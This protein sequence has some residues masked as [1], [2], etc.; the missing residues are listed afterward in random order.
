MKKNKKFIALI[1]LCVVMLSPLAC[2]KGFL[3]TTDSTA[4]TEEA[5]F[6]HSQDV[7]AMVNSVYDTYQSSDLLKKSI[8]YSANF[9]THDWYNNGS[10]IVW[11][12]YGIQSDFAALATLW[13]NAYVGIQRANSALQIITYAEG[14]GIVTPALGQRLTGE[15][16]FLRGTIYYYLTSVFGGVPLVLQSNTNGLQPRSTQDQCFQQ[17][18]ADMQQAES[19]LPSKTQYAA[20]DLGRATKGAAYGY[21]GA[22]QMWLKNYTAAMTAFTNTELTTNYS[23]VPSY[24]NVNEYNNQNNQES[25]FEVQFQISGSQS[26]DGGWQDGGEEAWIDDFDWPQEISGFGYDYANPGLEYS[27]EPG[28]TRKLATVAGPGDSLVSPGI[29]AK[30]GGIR[31]YAVVQAGFAANNSTYIGT[32]GKAI[33]TVGKV[34]QP[35][36]GTDGTPRSGYYCTKKWRDPTLTGANGTSAIFG[37]QNQVLLRYAEILLDEAE[38]EVHLGNTAQ[39]MAY[40]N[41]VRA[42]AFGTPNPP[43]MQS[44]VVSG[45]GS[46]GTTGGGTL[47]TTPVTDPLQMVLN[48]YRHELTADYSLFFDLRRAGPGVDAAFIQ[49]IYNTTS[50]PNQIYYPYGPTAD[51]KLHGVW[52]TSLTAGKD[53]L[54]IPITEFATNPNLVQNPGY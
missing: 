18:V 35:W 45:S 15:V 13:N 20:T 8:W 31:G 29:I 49:S 53:I 30:W 36:Y 44:I 38:C 4:A 50:S 23:L 9:L 41:Q 43:A 24:I 42:R 33:N 54:P 39:A 1:A 17:V 19:L 3:N 11:N 34:T 7:V 46:A 40:I 10:D 28:D 26:W 22:A 32:D 25:L 6:Q 5:T 12:Y 52:Q 27:F 51:G 37:G 2:R 14:K 21:E 16:L 47:V 48:E